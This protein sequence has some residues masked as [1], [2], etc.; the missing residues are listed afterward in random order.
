[1]SVRVLTREKK[2]WQISAS[3]FLVDFWS[4]SLFSFSL[5]VYSVCILLLIRSCSGE[6]TALRWQVEWGLWLFS[7]PTFSL[8]SETFS[9][10]LSAP[11]HQCGRGQF[12]TPP[13]CNSLGIKVIEPKE[14]WQARSREGEGKQTI[15]MISGAYG[16]ARASQLL[17]SHPA[18]H[19]TGVTSCSGDS[20][21]FGRTLCAMLVYLLTLT[22]APRP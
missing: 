6:K 20:V 1:M 15:S 10:L 14:E 3:S 22:E 4:R 7:S 21:T 12:Y 8:L 11:A 19:T 2:A 5:W 18:N 13:L 9:D 17:S 16:L